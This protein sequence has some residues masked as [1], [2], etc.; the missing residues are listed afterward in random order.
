MEL[1][2]YRLVLFRGNADAVI[3]YGNYHRCVFHP[4][5]HTDVPAFWRE[6]NGITQ[7][8]YQD[9]LDA[10][11]VGFYCSGNVGRR[12]E[13]MRLSLRQTT[14]RCQRLGDESREIECLGAQ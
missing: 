14:N 1:L 2:K 4:G 11:P 6:L 3:A 5:V 12:C 10:Q 7:Q 8:V 9:L 13:N